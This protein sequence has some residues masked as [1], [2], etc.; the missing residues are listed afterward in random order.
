MSELRPPHV[1]I[2]P[3]NCDQ[4]PIHIP[5]SI[6]PHGV[7]LAVDP[8]TGAVLQLAGDVE[9]L[10]GRAPEEAL[11]MSLGSLIG[12]DAAERLREPSMQDAA[13]SRSGVPIEAQI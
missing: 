3:A 10:L 13:L 7:L 8:K 4:E 9:R 11:Q 12:E 1:I 6:Q 5:G 2:D